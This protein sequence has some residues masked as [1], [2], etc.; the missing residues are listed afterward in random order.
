MQTIGLLGYPISH[1]FSKPYFEEK[2]KRL[3]LLDFQ[4]KLFE[5]SAIENFE[6]QLK[7]E[8]TLIGFSVTSPHKINIL[9]LL[10]KIHP[11]AEAIGAVNCVKVERK[12]NKIHLTGYNTDAFGFRQ[13]I[14]PFLEPHHQP[15]LIIGTGGAARAVEFALRQIGI[16]VFF[17]TRDKNRFFGSKNYI[18]FN[19]ITEAT[20]NRF[21]L[22]INTSPA[23]MLSESTNFP[24][25]PYSGISP[26]HFC[27]DLIYQPK[28]T[29]FLQKCAEQGAMV[30]NGLDMLY[31]QAE[32]AWKIW[33]SENN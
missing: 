14:K 15:A 2:F 11:D 9:R 24:M 19:E 18:E 6:S 17:L 3:Q 13:S 5:F 31:A 21:K 27:Y 23:E 8:N 30:M 25:L 22:I 4:F 20:I 7:N 33:S 29:V 10:H 28:E 16:D 26:E 1:S 32:K 12:E